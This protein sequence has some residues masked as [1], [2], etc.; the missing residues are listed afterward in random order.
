[1]KKLVDGFYSVVEDLGARKKLKL[2]L[3]VLLVAIALFGAF[4][5]YDI[6]HS[7]EFAENWQ[8]ILTQAADP[9]ISHNYPSHSH[10]ANI[11]FRFTP[12][13]IGRVLGISSINGYL[14]LQ[15]TAFTLFFVCTT[16]LFNK[17][18]GDSAESLI[19]SVSIA[20]I[21]TGNVLCSDYRGFFDVV[22]YLFILIAMLS[23]S[24][25]VIFASS[26]LGFYTDE[27]ALIASPLIYIFFVIGRDYSSDRNV[28]W[29]NFFSFNVK[30][31][32][33]VLSW[34]IYFVIRFSLNH[35]I[36]L[37]T[38]SAGM[39]NYLLNEAI[40]NIN[41]MPFAIWTG[42]EGFWVV[43]LSSFL[44][45][46][47]QKKWTVLFVY[48]A[49]QVII[50]FVA[51]CTFDITRGMAYLSPSIFISLYLLTESETPGVLRNT[52]L[53]TFLLC[54]FPTYYSGGP[55]TITWLYPLPLQ[56]LRMFFFES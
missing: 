48:S 22:A 50:I 38:N 13:L 43:V 36:G 4:P 27:R 34:I 24:P 2:F 45:L 41:A 11:A 1:M 46:L 16:R 18:R 35:F 54:L 10:S 25:L 28:T 31:T 53:I 9:F 56:I 39:V 26:L 8:S 23:E 20:F 51:L 32:A 14:L 30:M 12:V 7:S 42:L 15:L 5:S 40:E 52:V 6:V 47:V 21:F 3:P 37:K 29:K 55:N 44:V 49:A 19:L 33:L 17:I